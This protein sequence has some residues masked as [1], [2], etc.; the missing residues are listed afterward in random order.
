MEFFTNFCLKCLNIDTFASP[1]ITSKKFS[2]FLALF[3]RHFRTGRSGGMSSG[4]VSQLEV[5]FLRAAVVNS[6][7][8]PAQEVSHQNQTIYSNSSANLTVWPAGPCPAR[9]TLPTYGPREA[10]WPA[11]RIVNFIS[12]YFIY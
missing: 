2:I 7:Q 6:R 12:F 11:G 1:V 8:T 5:V 4:K 3:F 9:I 10:C